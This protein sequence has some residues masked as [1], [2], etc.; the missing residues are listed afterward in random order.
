[1]IVVGAELDSVGLR[2]TLR[3]QEQCGE[4]DRQRAYERRS[5][6]DDVI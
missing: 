5:R 4:Q 6:H 2:Q 1:M 3:E